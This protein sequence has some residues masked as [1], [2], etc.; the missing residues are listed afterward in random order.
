MCC[1]DN[2]MIFF[3]ADVFGGQ[4]EMRSYLSNLVGKLGLGL[5]EDAGL[6]VVVALPCQV[7][8]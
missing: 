7:A 4:V 1:S 2:K 3:T 5:A 8:G 6:G